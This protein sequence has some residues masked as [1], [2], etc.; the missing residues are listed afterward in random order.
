MTDDQIHLEIAS[1]VSVIIISHR[2]LFNNG[3]VSPL[4]F[5]WAPQ[6]EGLLITAPQCLWHIIIP[7][8]AQ[9]LTPCKC[10]GAGW[11]TRSTNQRG[12]PHRGDVLTGA[13]RD[14][15]GGGKG[16]HKHTHHRHYAA[17]KHTGSSAHSGVHPSQASFCLPVCNVGHAL[18]QQRLPFISAGA[19]SQ[20]ERVQT[21]CCFLS[22]NLL[23]FNEGWER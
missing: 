10:P 15:R 23:I 4:H 9:S 12:S 11:G 1:I 17:C 3:L 22:F 14:R 20:Q 16:R 21:C 2:A 18:N 8:D 6:R 7:A 19:G 5:R 13:E